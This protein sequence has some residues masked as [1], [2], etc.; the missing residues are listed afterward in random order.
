MNTDCAPKIET[1]TLD[2][3]LSIAEVRE[4]A[5]AVLHALRRSPS[6]TLDVSGVTHMDGAGLQLLML[7]SREAR[8]AGGALSLHE[9]SRAVAAALWAARLGHDLMPATPAVEGA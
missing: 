9:P 4:A 6:L 2:G 8:A 7:A 5:R 3:A 1:L